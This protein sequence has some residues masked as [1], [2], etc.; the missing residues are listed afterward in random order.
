MIKYNDRRINSGKQISMKNY[1]N[2]A[3]HAGVNDIER[4]VDDNISQWNTTAMQRYL[5]YAVLRYAG[6]ADILKY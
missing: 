5:Y 1:Y 3:D 4:H 2:K 6:H